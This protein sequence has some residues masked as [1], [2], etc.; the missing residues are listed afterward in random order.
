[1]PSSVRG[2]EPPAQAHT[3][4]S[5]VVGADPRGRSTSAVVW[6]AEEAQRTGH[7]LVVVTA[8][9]DPLSAAD[10]QRHGMVSLAR[11]LTLSD[12]TFH[13]ASGSPAAALLTSAQAADVELLVVGRRSLGAAPRA[14]I[15]RTSRAVAGRAQV[16]VIV[17]PEPWI[18]PSMSS[19]PIVVGVG[20]PDVSTGDLNDRRRDEAALAW[21]FERAAQVHVPLIVVSA[22]EMPPIYSWSPADVQ[23][24]RHRHDATL[25]ERLV[26]WCRSYPRLE[27]IGRSLPEPA[28]LALLDA[29][30]EAQLTVVG[31]HPSAQLGG[32]SLGGTTRNVLNGAERPVAVVPQAPGHV[33]EN[34][35][36]APETVSQGPTWAPMF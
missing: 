13:D 18:Q 30:K 1:M 5:I 34:A 21:A 32:F 22:W 12:V 24:L 10:V 7:Q 36:Q 3:N 15:G 23:A 31:R 11:R 19:A 17:V 2:I 9:D 29:S 25:D 28:H 35:V 14:V 26:S 20:A 27:V 8:H 6:A 16:P 4:H 33:P